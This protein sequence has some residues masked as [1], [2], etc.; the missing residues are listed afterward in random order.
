LGKPSLIYKKCHAHEDNSPT[1]RGKKA[2]QVVDPKSSGHA[3]AEY[4]NSSKRPA[5]F[6]REVLARSNL[7]RGEINVE[8]L[9][10]LLEESYRIVPLHAEVLGQSGIHGKL[11]P[12]YRPALARET[13]DFVFKWGI[14]LVLGSHA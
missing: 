6:R 5:T 9:T 14:S 12:S 3:Q 11:V 8:S 4:D 7:Q 13:Q 2:Y 10:E 1:P